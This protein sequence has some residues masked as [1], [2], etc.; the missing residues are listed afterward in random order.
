MPPT[1]L[2]VRVVPTPAGRLAGTVE[3]V[4]TG[5]RHRF[6]GM[7]ELARLIERLTSTG[8]SGLS[9]GGFDRGFR[10]AVDGAGHAYVTGGTDSP[11]FPTRNALQPS[12]GGGISDGFVAK[13]NAAG[14]ALVFST[15]LGGSGTDVGRG[16][17][18]DLAAHVYVTGQT[19]S[20]DFPTW[21]PLQVTNAGGFDAFMAKL[22]AAGTAF[23]YSTY[24]GGSDI[25]V[26][27]DIAVDPAGHAA[28]TQLP[29]PPASVTS[30]LPASASARSTC[31]REWEELPGVLPGGDPEVRRGAA[32]VPTA[33]QPRCT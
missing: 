28:L 9:M 25:D 24:L 10:V 3:R 4:R 16:I 20:P 2:I 13:L 18:V 23:V 26:A 32:P 27:F 14:N 31:R 30:S 19:E 6:Q 29:Q 8:E 1:T 12:F 21:K 15:Y 22:T 7:A 33:G 17:T 11:N 5:E